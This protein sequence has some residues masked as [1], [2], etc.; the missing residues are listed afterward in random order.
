MTSRQRILAVTV[1]AGLA[2]AA[3]L[4]FRNESARLARMEESITTFV[5]T[6]AFTDVRARCQNDPAKLGPIA[7]PDRDSPAFEVFAYDGEFHA[8]DPTAP[9]FSLELADKM[10]GKLSAIGKFSSPEGNGIELGMATPWRN[11][12]CALILVRLVAK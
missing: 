7:G 5:T 1:V 8:A 9:A 6:P 4:Y 11:G 10:R 12:P 3:I 2:V